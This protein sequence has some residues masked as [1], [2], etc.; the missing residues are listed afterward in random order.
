MN[1]EFHTNNFN[2]SNKL[3]ED[4]LRTEYRSRL[5]AEGAEEEEGGEENKSR[6]TEYFRL[7]AISRDQ[8]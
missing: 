8:K 4:R 2:G 6:G 3:E 5:R 1:K 7:T